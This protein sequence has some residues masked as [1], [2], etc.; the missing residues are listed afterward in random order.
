MLPSS[1]LNVVDFRYAT[2]SPVKMEQDAVVAL[3]IQD[4][5]KLLQFGE[6][7]IE[8]RIAFNAT[9]YNFHEANEYVLIWMTAMYPPFRT[10]KD[11]R[12]LQKRK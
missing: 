4:G 1:N 9:D 2:L 6:G 11:F 3:M 12:G 5:L 10:M 7:T 8:L